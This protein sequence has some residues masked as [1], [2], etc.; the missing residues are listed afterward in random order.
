MEFCTEL[1]SQI[2]VL[3]NALHWPHFVDNLVY[4]I[5]LV[6][7]W[8]LYDA[9]KLM[10][11]DKLAKLSITNKYRIKIDVHNIEFSNW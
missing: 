5:G 2:K 8:S 10:F 6:G 9:W 4:K 1:E 7:Y 3:V 11:F